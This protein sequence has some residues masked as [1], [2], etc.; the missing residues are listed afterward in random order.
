[1]LYVTRSGSCC[2]PLLLGSRL[3][4]TGVSTRS[5][6]T[7]YVHRSI[8]FTEPAIQKDVSSSPIAYAEQMQVL[9]GGGLATRPVTG[10]NAVCQKADSAQATA[11]LCPAA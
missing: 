11:N 2:C 7:S 5:V 9:G 3:L 6:V 1:M 8:G 4:G 10:H